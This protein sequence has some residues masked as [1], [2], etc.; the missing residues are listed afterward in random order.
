MSLNYY[1]ESEEFVF[2][3]ATP[4]DMQGIIELYERNYK[5]PMGLTESEKHFIW[6]YLNNPVNR[7][8]ILLAISKAGE[9]AAQYAVLPKYLIVGNQKVICT[10]SQ[11]T[12]TDERFRGRGLFTFLADELYNEIQRDGV[13]FTYGFPNRNSAHG[14]FTKLK[15]REV[16]PLNIMVKP[17]Y[18]K[19]CDYSFFPYIGSHPLGRFIGKLAVVL[20]NSAFAKTAEKD[21]SIHE[22]NEFSP[23][24]DEIWER[25]RYKNLVMVIRDNQYIKWRFFDKP[26]NNYR[27]FIFY[28]SG[29]PA[30]YL[31]TSVIKKFGAS[32]LFV[33]DFVTSDSMI[34]KSMIANIDQIARE[35]SAPIISVMVPSVYKKYFYL[36]GYVR[37]PQRLF[38]QDL[39][40]GVRIHNDFENASAIY[41]MNNWYLTWSDID[42]V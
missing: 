23:V 42:V 37:L 24:F 41:D 12:V 3:S 16:K 19:G 9:F 2:R 35:S 39:Y 18:C 25:F 26:E 34:L 32:N 15:W 6:E 7:L 30:G 11:D 20:H 21:V 1:K 22:M 5:K 33:V 38:P 29:R 36:S 27:T 28:K 17:V 4:E 14:F 31:I 8:Y 40:F 13:L 10:L